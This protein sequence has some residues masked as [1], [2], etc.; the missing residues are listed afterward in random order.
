MRKH[1]ETLALLLQLIS[2]QNCMYKMSSK[3]HTMRIIELIYRP[4]CMS[5]Q[6][7]DNRDFTMSFQRFEIQQAIKR[8]ALSYPLFFE[9]DIKGFIGRFMLHL[10]AK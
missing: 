6:I 8:E 4:L 9:M 5:T 1:L 3:E 7:K 2:P 10:G